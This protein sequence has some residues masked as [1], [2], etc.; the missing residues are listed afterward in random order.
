M[1]IVGE[2][3]RKATLKAVTDCRVAAVPGDAID[4]EA[5]VQIAESRPAPE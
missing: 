3:K 5:L 2:G 4:R 1:A